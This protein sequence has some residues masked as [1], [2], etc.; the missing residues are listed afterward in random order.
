MASWLYEWKFEDEEEWNKSSLGEK[1]SWE[2]D[3]RMIEM[4]F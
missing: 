1:F 4:V 3:Y 2:E